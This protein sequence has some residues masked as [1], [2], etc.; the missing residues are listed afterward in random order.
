MFS[1][2]YSPYLFIS[3]L[4][5]LVVAILTWRR[6]SAPGA[7]PLALLLFTAFIWSFSNG[8]ILETKDPN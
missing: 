5:T 2:P 7:T 3:A 8:M 4:I 6:R 1:N